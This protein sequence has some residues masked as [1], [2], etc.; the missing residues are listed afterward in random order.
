LFIYGG[1]DVKGNDAS[2]KYLWTVDPFVD[3]PEWKTYDIIDTDLILPSMYSC[4][5]IHLDGI[6]RHTI[7]IV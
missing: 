1:T 3:D 4:L 6:Q 5:L 7:E 2:T